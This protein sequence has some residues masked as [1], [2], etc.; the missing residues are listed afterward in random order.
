MIG[1]RINE[2]RNWKYFKVNDNK[3]KYI[4]ILWYNAEAVLTEKYI[5]SHAYKLIICYIESRKKGE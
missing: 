3:I 2:K 1:K 4:K 5:V